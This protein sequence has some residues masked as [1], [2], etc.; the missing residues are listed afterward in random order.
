MAAI[1]DLKGSLEPQLDAVAV[2]VGLLRADLQKVSD[3]VSTAETDI[4]CL[5]SKSK[6]LDEQVRFFTTEHEGIAACL[7]DQKVQAQRKNIRV[8]GVLKG[9]KDPSV[10]LFVETPITDHLCPRR[11]SSFFMV[12]WVHRAPVPHLRP[13]GPRGPSLH[14]SLISEIGMTWHF[15]APE[16][17]WEWLEGS[18]AAAHPDLRQEKGGPTSRKKTASQTGRQ[19]GPTDVPAP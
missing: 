7:E 2:G 12:E 8:V 1:H 3:K 19:E 16:K 9:A 15:A 10:E 5:Q 13:G 17:T 14:A 18:K 11:L 4:A 6:T